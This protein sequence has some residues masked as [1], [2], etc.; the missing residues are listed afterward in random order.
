MTYPQN[1]KE[2][3]NYWIIV[4][5]FFSFLPFFPSVQYINIIK[6]EAIYFPPIFEK[7]GSIEMGSVT[8]SAVSGYILPYI[9]VAIKAS[10]F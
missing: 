7:G 6:L 8:I 10:C 9:S 5:F 3:T 4:C 2:F 1:G